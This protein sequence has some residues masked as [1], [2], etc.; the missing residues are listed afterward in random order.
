MHRRGT[1]APSGTRN[2]GKGGEVYV[3]PHANSQSWYVY[4]VYVYLYGDSAYT[5]SS[6]AHEAEIN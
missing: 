6:L 1:R 3:E 5:N 4:F 2:Y